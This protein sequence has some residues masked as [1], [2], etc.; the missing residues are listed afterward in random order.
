MKVWDDNISFDEALK[1]DDDILS[2]LAIKEIDDLFKIEKRL[3]N[4]DAIFTR[5]GLD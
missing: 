2:V 4:L 1:G 5:L 3:K